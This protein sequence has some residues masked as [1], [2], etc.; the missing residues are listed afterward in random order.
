MGT[1]ILFGSAGKSRR[2]HVRTVWRAAAILLCLAAP[3]ESAAASASGIAFAAARAD[4]SPAPL[5]AASASPGEIPVYAPGGHPAA[6]PSSGRA[7]AEAPPDPPD[8][9]PAAAGRAGS[10]PLPPADRLILLSVPGLSFLELGKDSLA[11]LPRLRSLLEHAAVGAM[12]IRTPRAGMAGVYLSLGA[13]L[14]AVPAAEAGPLQADELR[15]GSSGAELY[16]RFAG[17]PLSAAV[18]EPAADGLRRTNLRGPFGSRPGAF[19]EALARAGISRSVWGSAAPGPAGCCEAPRSGRYAAWLLM[20]PDGQVPDGDISGRVLLRDPLR[21]FG[22]KADPAQL[23]RPL[24]S[25][26]ARA[27]VLL[28]WGDLYRL[29]RDKAHYGEEAFAGRKREALAELDAFIGALLPAIRGRTG[30]W[31]FSPEV[32]ADARRQ[33]SLLAPAIYYAEGLSP[34]LLTSPTTK[35]SGLLAYTDAAPTWLAQ[36]GAAVPPEMI[37]CPAEIESGGAALGRLQRELDKLAR[38]YRLRPQLLYPFAVYE[39]LVLSAGLLAIAA[40]RPVRPGL[41]RLLLRLLYTLPAAPPAMLLSG[42]LAALPGWFQ[43][44][45]VLVF[46]A[47]A[48]RIALLMEW[49]TSLAVLC[50]ATA[51]LIL[52]DGLSGSHAMK[53]SVLGYDA[54]IG[55]RYYGIGNEYMGVLLGAVALGWAAGLQAFFRLYS[56]RRRRGRLSQVPLLWSEPWALL[57]FAAVALYLALPNAGSNA[58]GALAA[59]ATF[60]TAWLRIYRPGV[61]SAAGKLPRRGSRL[62]TALRHTGFAA[63]FTAAALALL[64][65]CNQWFAGEPSGKSHIGRAMDRVKEGDFAYIG[66]MM[67]RKLA[68]NWHLFNV[69]VW[70]KVLVAGLAVVVV[71]LLLRAGPARRWEEEEPILIRGL[72]AVGLGAAAALL[73]NDSGIVAAATMIIYAAVPLLMMGV[74]ELQARGKPAKAAPAQDTSDSQSL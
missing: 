73:V 63:A 27:V 5:R 54:M 66:R 60:G 61:T 51:G 17:L 15:S 18:A 49:K 46:V 65:L 35:R 29:Y 32:N 6:P 70:S 34:G 10:A 58:G 3:V 62:Q 33:R 71:F 37:G 57:L 4:I 26:P 25:L 59:A 28:E 12:N 7:A 43:T 22:V 64:W 24:Q 16:R 44:L 68:M 48:S 40:R 56:R 8:T 36:L 55:A 39:V 11:R 67:A 30:L 50:L 45:F 14:P 21:P 41:A 19:G 20:T 53:H 69:S 23:L 13:G 74:G 72:G 38:I 31:L 42:W 2:G 9:G 47:A 1:R 52:A